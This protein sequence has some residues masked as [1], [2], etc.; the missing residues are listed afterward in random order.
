MAATEIEN[1]S[2]QKG[3]MKHPETFIVTL[4]DTRSAGA[5][6]PDK[7][8]YCPSAIGTEHAAGCV[9]RQRSVVVDLTIRYVVRVPEHWTKDDIEFHRNEGTW[10]T[11]NALEELKKYCG[12]NGCLC[13]YS[14]TTVVREATE[15]DV[16]ANLG[17]E[18]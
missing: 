2:G 9:I 4:D 8:F 17:W 6:T 15:R 12:E 13:A 18:L 10:C 3:L 11:D 7:C 5:G 1:H 16:E 14:K